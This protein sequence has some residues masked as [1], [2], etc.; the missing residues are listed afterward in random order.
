MSTKSIAKIC[1]S[2]FV[3]WRRG[4]KSIGLLERSGE[5]WSQ[6]SV[7]YERSGGP[8]SGNGAD[9]GEHREIG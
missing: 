7:E 6:N 3:A 8:L 9:S 4:L 2:E 5:R 1:Q